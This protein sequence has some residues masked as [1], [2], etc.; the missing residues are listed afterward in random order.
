[1]NIEEI[2]KKLGDVAREISVLKE[3]IH[4]VEMIGPEADD[5]KQDKLDELTRLEK[6][7]VEI[8]GELVQEKA[9]LKAEIKE[10][11]KTFMKNEKE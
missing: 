2:D 11:S 7:Q 1:M 3:L 6:M 5:Y 4:Y 8:E 9:R 10:M